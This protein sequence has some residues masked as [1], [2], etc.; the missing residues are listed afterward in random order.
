MLKIF[1]F[2][3]TLVHLAIGFALYALSRPRVARQSVREWSGG[4][5]LPSDTGTRCSG[6]EGP[7][8]RAMASNCDMAT[9][10]NCSL[11]GGDAAALQSARSTY[12]SNH[13]D[14]SDVAIADSTRETVK[15]SVA[16][17]FRL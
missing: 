11:G 17:V 16:H 10:K 5:C 8:L 9:G 15:K 6:R 13:L 2:R 7:Q 1:G 3:I 12:A 14:T 4:E